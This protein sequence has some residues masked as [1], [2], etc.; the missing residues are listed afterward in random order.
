[1]PD[2]KYFFLF[3]ILLFLIFIAMKL[4]QIHEDLV[5]YRPCRYYNQKWD[6]PMHEGSNV[7]IF[8]QKC[9]EE[10]EEN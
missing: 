1:M 5:D 7:M 9:S 6:L 8:E 2:L 3:F 10:C 4:G